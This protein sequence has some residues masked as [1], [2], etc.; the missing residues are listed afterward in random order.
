VFRCLRRAEYV[1]VVEAA[2][3]SKLDYPNGIIAKKCEE[4]FCD[5][6]P[7]EAHHVFV[8][9]MRQR[10]TSPQTVTFVSQLPKCL[11]ALGYATP[12]SE[13]Q[14]TTAVSVL[15]SKIDWAIT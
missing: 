10:Q 6:T 3:Q 1:H 8:N 7:E 12:L 9:A 11:R 5:F 2:L 4:Y 14:R 15:D 13:R